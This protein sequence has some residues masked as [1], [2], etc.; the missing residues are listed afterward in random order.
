M[1][2]E[3][4]CPFCGFSKETSEQAIPDRA[5]WAICPRCR[6]KF[7]MPLKVEG[8]ASEEMDEAGGRPGLEQGSEIRPRRIGAPWERASE[9]GFVR[10]VWQTFA[11]VLFSPADFFRGVTVTGGMMEPLA[12]GLLAGALGN[13]LGL[14]WPVLLVSGGLFPFGEIVLPRLGAGLIFLVLAVIIPIS[15]TLGMYIYSGV[16]HLLLLIVRGA[17]NGFEATFRVVAYSHAAQ[18]WEVIPVI[19]SWVGGIWRVVVWV[20][21]L[22]EIHHTSYSRVIVAFLV[23]VGFL[24]IVMIAVII[25]FLL[26]LI[27]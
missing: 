22:R 26:L 5:K 8:K 18:A 15:V 20:V 14:F 21:G 17:T 4:V 27:Q 19:G 1:A 12:F 11:G 9:I 16:L 23:P 10:G 25:P 3:L 24:A 7:E 2:V 13:M 6:Q